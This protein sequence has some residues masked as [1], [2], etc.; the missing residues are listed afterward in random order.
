MPWTMKPI[1]HDDAATAR[2]GATCAASV[3]GYERKAL[4]D[5]MWRSYDI[6][7]GKAIAAIK[8]HEF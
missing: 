1:P 3:P 8:P 7:D 6:L 4:S 2:V 5:F